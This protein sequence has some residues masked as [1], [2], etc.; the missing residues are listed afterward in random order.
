MT[1]AGS[2]VKLSTSR[3]RCQTREQ[4]RIPSSPHMPLPFCQPGESAELSVAEPLFAFVAGRPAVPLLLFAP[5]L[6][7]LIVTDHAAGNGTSYAMMH[8]MAGKTADI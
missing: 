8:E 3:R 2:D 7:D 4:C 5:R 1:A 6:G